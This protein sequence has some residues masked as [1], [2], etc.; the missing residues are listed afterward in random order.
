MK[1]LKYMKDGGEESRVW[2]FYFVEMK[3]LFSIALLKFED[4]SR[5]AYHDHA[6]SAISWILKGRLEESRR[7]GENV[8]E[9]VFTPSIVPIITTR[10]NMHKVVSR[11]RTWALTFRGPWKDTWGE[12]LP[13][14]KKYRTLTHG[15]KVVGERPENTNDQV[16]VITRN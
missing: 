16:A 6:F 10:D 7:S 4:G 15:R 1:F 9:S 2:G 8:K 3:G 13:S 11:G 5:D 14:L 12:Y